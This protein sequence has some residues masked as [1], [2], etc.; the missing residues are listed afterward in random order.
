MPVPTEARGGG[1]RDLGVG[2]GVVVVRHP[3]KVQKSLQN[4]TNNIT[5]VDK[6]DKGWNSFGVKMISYSAVSESISP[7]NGKG[8]EC[9]KSR[10]AL[11]LGITASN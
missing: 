6:R 11:G 1:G 3:Q 10:N 9:T 4:T 2:G 7:S 8:L 5:S